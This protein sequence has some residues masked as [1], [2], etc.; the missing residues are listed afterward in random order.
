[1]RCKIY[2]M[3]VLII[4]TTLESLAFDKKKK[5][6]SNYHIYNIKVLNARR[7][8]KTGKKT[9]CGIA[10]TTPVVVKS[11]PHS[12]L[13][14]FVFKLDGYYSRVSITPVTK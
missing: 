11:L 1:M 12:L 9:V 3:Y 4:V 10:S 8:K 2:T 7:A 6:S 13:S 14:K 5:N